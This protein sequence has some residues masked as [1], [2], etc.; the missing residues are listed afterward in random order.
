VPVNPTGNILEQVEEDY[1]MDNCLTQVCL[2]VTIKM[3]W[4]VC[5][6]VF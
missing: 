1:Q 6:A 2:E 4:F 3:P 5:V